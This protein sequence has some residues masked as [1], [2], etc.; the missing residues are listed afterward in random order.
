MPREP[1]DFVDTHVHFWHLK[2]PTLRYSWLEPSAVHPILG[3]ID[4]IKALA[5]DERHLHA[6]SRF[7]GL[8]KAVHVQA[9]VGTDDP[10]AE[11]E[12]L[13]E[14]AALGR[15]PHAVVADVDLSA[16][17]AP[18]ILERHLQSPLM[19][20][21]RDFTTEHYLRNPEAFPV[22]EDGLGLLQE[23]G[24]VF[25]MDCEWPNMAAAR[26]LAER[27]SGL[28]FVLEHIGYPRLRTKEYFDSWR[29]GIEQLALA[30]NVH[31][32]ISGVGMRDP[33]W[34]L[35]SIRPWVDHCIQAFGPDRCVFGTNWPVDRLYS[36]YDAI[37][38]AYARCIEAYSE[39][40]QRSMF[41]ENATV[42]YRL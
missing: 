27:Y 11:T 4:G 8:R 34:T 42:L 41:N 33:L 14:M 15:Y 21:V 1:L 35:N 26:R 23:A 32:K 40:E 39:A 2:H 20:G 36:S 17:S 12:W 9:A 16:K 19:R 28:T 3:D 22:F 29:Q 25:D 30:P 5:F 13:T 24:L 18:S 6:E 31:C 37:V 38:D 7:S 10:V